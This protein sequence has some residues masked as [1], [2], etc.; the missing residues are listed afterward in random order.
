MKAP[1]TPG[2]WEWDGAAL[3]AGPGEYVL[4]PSN[5]ISEPE[6]TKQAIGACGISA[7]ACA[8]ANAALMARAPEMAELLMRLHEAYEAD[9]AEL[10]DMGPDIGRMLRTIGVR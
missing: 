9:P 5:S 3:K 8:N 6:D 7:E 4:W 10:K 2:P 1:W